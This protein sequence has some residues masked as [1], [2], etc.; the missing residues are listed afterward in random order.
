MLAMITLQSINQSHEVRDIV[1][2]LK[3]I[4]K[5]LKNT[6]EKLNKIEKAV[7]TAAQIAKLVVAVAQKLGPLAVGV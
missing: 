5:D 6:A 2:S 4:A 1:S 7:E 3:G